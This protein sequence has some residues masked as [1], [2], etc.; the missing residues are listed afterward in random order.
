MIYTILYPHSYASLNYIIGG[1]PSY[2]EKP[3]TYNLK[4]DQVFKDFVRELRECKVS[5]PSVKVRK[6][7]N[8]FV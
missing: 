3:W 5:L 6:G 2:R 4:K 7:K 8:E 1:T